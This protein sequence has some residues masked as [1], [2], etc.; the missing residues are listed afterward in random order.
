LILALLTALGLASRSAAQET[1]QE[2]L[3][4]RAEDYTSI[5]WVDGFP[6]VVPRASWRRCIQTGY[7]A[8]VLNTET[9]KVP[10]FGPISAGSSYRASGHSGAPVWQELSPAE[11][12]L[13]LT[14]SG[15]EYR[16]AG[17]EKWSRFAGPRLIESGR[18]VQRADVTGLSFVSDD[19]ETLNVEARFETVA[20]PDR[21]ALILAVRPGVLPDQATADRSQRTGGGSGRGSRPTL[22]EEWD[23]ATMEIRFRTPHGEQTQRREFSTKGQ[24]SGQRWHE[25][26]LSL[27][28]TS[29]HGESTTSPV[30]VRANELPKGVARPVD[31]D[32]ARGWHRVD[33]DGIEPIMP[34]GRQ[35][36]ANDAIE[37]IK[38]VLSN[39]EEQEQV[40]RL[41]FAKGSGGIRQRI[42]S[43]ITGVS[44][45]L[46][47]SAGI[48]TGIPVQLSKN[49]HTRRE[50]GV[51]A[52]SW[53]HGFSQ[54]RLPAGAKVEL[55]L[56]L[57]YGHWGGVPA[58]SHAQLCL[59]GWGSNQHWS[60]SA[61]GSWG[62]SICYEPDQAQANCT[63]TDVRP[64]MVNSGEGDQ[65][66]RWTSNVG[67]GDFFR[68][69]S[70]AGNRVAHSAMRTIYQRQGPCL[71]EVIFAGNVGKGITHSSTV[72]LARTDDIVR[73]VYQLRMDVNKATD[74]SRFVIFQIGADT[75]SYTGERKMAIGDETGLTQQW[76]TQWGGDTYRTERIKCTG[77]IPWVSLHDAVP[78]DLE[79]Y[80]AWANRGIII[81]SWKAR[82][83]GKDASPWFAERGVTI[84]RRESSTLDIL[85]PPGLVRLEPGDFIEATI[86]H[87]V[88][89]QF[90]RYYYGPNKA[91]RVA[92]GK[93]EN[94]WRMIHREALGNDR[95]VEI[96]EGTIE[97]LY[98]DLRI[99]TDGDRSTFKLSGGLAYVPITLTG[100]ASHR[101]YTLT[102]DGKP[103]DQNVHGNDYWQT[104][105][106]PASRRWSRTYNVPVNGDKIHTIRA[107]PE[108][109]TK[110]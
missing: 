32:A 104:D 78:R 53:L 24:A 42:G 110:P 30:I 43:P 88:M 40:A 55:E 94:T 26:A 92:L 86:E 41:L 70:P 80:G 58:A 49:W 62:E 101:E 71:T 17:A 12:D 35:P 82:L 103:V 13:T 56:T 76:A 29:F 50:G 46:R 83:G 100:L 107:Y 109:A 61:L 67:G 106:D 108:T 18:F 28:P 34:N 47:D 54:V 2:D 90:A 91:L 51:Y 6:G 7:F 96:S 105:Y 52:G 38:L 22:R 4:P 31:Y 3:M 10:H 8:M 21:L 77:R 36:N 79:K 73:G 93:D 57:N 33:L 60:Q 64:V 85:P 14:V 95:R 19:D 87:I 48:P 81:R 27:N 72:S 63:I 1:Q 45:T 15:K 44:A 66:W 98:P 9:L 89:P 65:R 59:V 68:F 37:R 20:W 74:F 25:V 84:H 69:F 39:P 5:W 23:A 102:V 16:C 99:R 11:L 75:Y 97:R